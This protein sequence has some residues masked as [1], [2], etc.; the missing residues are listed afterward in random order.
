MKYELF[1]DS[2][3]FYFLQSLGSRFILK[4]TFSFSEVF[5][6]FKHVYIRFVCLIF[7]LYFSFNFNFYVKSY[8]DIIFK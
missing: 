7:N 5:L 2:L 1:F 3:V 6:E 8:F 4:K